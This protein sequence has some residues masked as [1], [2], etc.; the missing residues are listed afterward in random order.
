MKTPSN[1]RGARGFLKALN[2]NK[3]FLFMLLPAIAYIVILAYLP[4]TGIVLAFKKYTYAGGIFGSP[5]NG[6]KNFEF[7]F[8]SG[9]ALLVTTNTVLYNALFI[10]FN[11]VL[12]ISVAV[13]LSEL[14]GKHFKKISQ[15]MMF[16]PYFI[17]WV[18]VSVIAFNILSYDVGAINTMLSSVGAEKIS[19]YS[20]GKWWPLI[21]TLFG[22]WKSVGY[23]SILY[24]AAIMGV[25]IQIYEAAVVDGANVFQRIFKVTIP[26]IMPTVIILLLLSIGGIFRG[27]FDMFYNLV[28]S[29]GML[30]SATDVI[31]TFTFRALMTNSDFGMSAASGLYQSVLCFIT[32]L[33]ANKLIKMYEKDYSL[34]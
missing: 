15:S 14:N 20:D 28:G 3:V 31:D 7:F 4:M 1:S 5:W 6:L 13:L 19:F 12:Q 34:F 23:G 9:K 22:A 11:T 30:Y 10:A 2:M 18:V 16:L 21:L 26:Q 27:N 24:L 29:N 25:D 17:S 33:A 32:I 8:K